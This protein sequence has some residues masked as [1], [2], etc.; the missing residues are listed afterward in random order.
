MAGPD[1]RKQLMSV[2]L[3]MTVVTAVFLLAGVMVTA[4]AGAGAML[5][6]LVNMGLAIIG[7]AVFQALWSASLASPMQLMVDKA[8]QG[9]LD[10]LPEH[11]LAMDFVPLLRAL[12][13]GAAR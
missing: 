6:I 13:Q 8:I 4:W 2:R 1:T 7:I 3:Q 10:D 11:S 12:K 9:R 5:P